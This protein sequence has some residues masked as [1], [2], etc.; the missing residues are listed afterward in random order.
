MTS[1]YSEIPEVSSSTLQILTYIIDLK[2]KVFIKNWI[3][4]WNHEGIG[5]SEEGKKI[6][7]SKPNGEKY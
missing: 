2:K 5:N 3:Q 4:C 6:I 1:W 7:A